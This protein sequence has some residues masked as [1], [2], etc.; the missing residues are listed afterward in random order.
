M[1]F[2]RGITLYLFSAIPTLIQ[3]NYQSNIWGI[4]IK[5]MKPQT[6]FWSRLATLIILLAL[7][8]PF[9]A[10]EI[11]FQCKSAPRDGHSNKIEQQPKKQDTKTD[12]TI[13]VAL[14]QRQE[15]QKND[16]KQ[17]HHG[18]QHAKTRHHSDEEKHKNHVYDYS[19]LKHKRKTI[20]DMFGFSA[21]ILVALSYIA[22]LLSSYGGFAH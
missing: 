11:V 7:T 16:E 9:R 15:K 2:V 18:D 20:T 5:N 14:P 6:I 22:V 19:R 4:K 17:D 3:G 12:V 1:R 10:D 13:P 8:V 21:K